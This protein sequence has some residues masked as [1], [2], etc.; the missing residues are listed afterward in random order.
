VFPLGAV[1]SVLP[2]S[3]LVWAGV[4]RTYPVDLLVAV[5]AAASAGF[6]YFYTLVRPEF[7]LAKRVMLAVWVVGG[8]W[9]MTN[10]LFAGSWQ[11]ALGFA[12]A[13]QLAALYWT[14]VRP[15]PFWA[16]VALAV[17]FGNRTE[18]MLTTPTLL[19]FLLRHDAPAGEPWLAVL[20]RNWLHVA[21]FGAAP[22][23]L[24]LATLAYNRARFGSITDFGYAHIPGVLR[25]PWYQHGIFSLYSLNGN[26][27]QMLFEGWRRLHQWPFLIPTGWGGSIVLASPFLLLLVRK[28]RGD[29]VRVVLA[30]LTIVALT[31]VLWLHGNPG[32]WQYSYR[33]AMILLPWFLVLLVEYLP[34]QITA[35]EMG[36]WALSV[37]ISVYATYLFMWSSYLPQ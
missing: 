12:V 10:L 15:R 7:S 31:L 23:V 32:G 22:V 25:E 19:V 35:L 3:A 18:V 24:G 26:A 33:Y 13:G 17:A 6:A 16:G 8:T 37:G 4:L 2:L 36:L 21:R 28:P 30:W 14:V 11:L 27:Q 34:T 1:V 29:S 9:F 5:L 20:R